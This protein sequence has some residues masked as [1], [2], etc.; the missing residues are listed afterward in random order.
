[1]P[2]DAA[3][4]RLDPDAA[5]AGRAE[6]VLIDEWQTVPE[7]LGA[8]KRSVDADPRPG[9]FL[10][11]GSVITGETGTWAG[12]GR[13][14]TLP[15][16]GLS[17]AERLGRGGAPTFLDRV[18]AGPV[19]ASDFAR[20]DWSLIDVLDA[21]LESGYPQAALGPQ[22]LARTAWLSSYLDHL[23]LRDI[24][25]LGARNP[26]LL[27]RY[28]DALAINTAGV[29]TQATILQAAGVNRQTGAAYDDDLTRTFAYEA[30]PAWHSNRLNRLVK[31]PK[32]YITDTA[33]ASTAAGVDAAAIL[34]DEN[35]LG[36]M[37]DT[38]VASQLR[39][40]AAARVPTPRLHHLR[41]QDGRREVDL[42]VETSAGLIAIE[43][44]AS[45]APDRRDA[46]HLEWLVD[47]LGEKVRLGVLFSANP[48]P[49]QLSDRIVALPFS[50]LW[51]G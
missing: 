47:E 11:T 32:R 15:L 40:Q 28:L 22:G 43:V 42:I 13:I 49:S 30:V 7:V 33:L 29:T 3:S 18:L 14:V 37:L 38:F 34:A 36:R 25:A 17:V 4:V 9:R 44:K 27:R 6:P 23:V 24:P 1:V 19:T 16:W 5:L 50:S 48:Q 10:L 46:R 51:E 45:A 26:T 31:L 39:I 35:L 2:A 21:A 12:T 8:V 41:D 20:S